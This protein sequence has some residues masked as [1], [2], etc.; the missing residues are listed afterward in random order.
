[1]VQKDQ[2]LV[3]EYRQDGVKPR[4]H[5]VREVLLRVGLAG[6]ISRG[7]LEERL[8]LLLLI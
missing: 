5:E 2:L 8:H 1:M 3:S 7:D 6:E 4:R